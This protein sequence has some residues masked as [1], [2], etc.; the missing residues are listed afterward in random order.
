MR[1]RNTEIQIFDEDRGVIDGIATL[2]DYHALNLRT[3]DII[4]K[5]KTKSELAIFLASGDFGKN[6]FGASFSLFSSGDILRERLFRSKQM[7]FETKDGEPTQK[8]I[9]DKLLSLI[10]KGTVFF[11]PEPELLGYHQLVGEYA[12]FIKSLN[13]NSNFSDNILKSFKR[14][15]KRTIRDDEAYEAAWDSFM[16]DAKQLTKFCENMIL[17]QTELRP[18]FPLSFTRMV[19]NTYS[20]IEHAAILNKECNSISQA[21][22]LPPVLTVS[23][24]NTALSRTKNIMALQEAIIEKN[25]FGDAFEIAYFAFPNQ[26]VHDNFVHRKNFLSVIGIAKK[27]QAYGVSVVFGNL[28][29]SL[30]LAA[31]G[32]GINLV[33][34]PIDGNTILREHK[35]GYVNV[36]KIPIFEQLD[37]LPFEDFKDEYDLNGKRFPFYSATS[38]EL[39]NKNFPRKL[40]HKD[41]EEIN[42]KRKFIA[43][44]IIDELNH[45]VFDGIKKKETM[46]GIRQRLWQSNKANLCKLFSNTD[47]NQ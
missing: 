23:I 8:S 20:S 26:C 9:E 6:T 10:N 1:N 30:A 29:F 43:C 24:G 18:K 37:W 46:E 16:K 38:R 42:Y 4:P 22:G 27:L 31:L 17:Y 15:E 19:D 25:K 5:I 28:E 13:P 47:N 14:K 7:N 40:P 12:S 32:K 2:N 21:S 44:D 45:L 3:C 35:G 36:G 34:S 11:E 39:D 33:T 41:K